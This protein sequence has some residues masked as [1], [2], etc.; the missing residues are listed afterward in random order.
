MEERHIS[1]WVLGIIVVLALVGLFLLFKS[2][3]TGAGFVASKSYPIEGRYGAYSNTNPFPYYAPTYGVSP[4]EIPGYQNRASYQHDW[5]WKM[6]N[7]SNTRDRT[8]ACRI[9]NGRNLEPGNKCLRHGKLRAEHKRAK[10][11]LLQENTNIL[12]NP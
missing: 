9:H 1:L 12:D 11:I 7:T 10:R 2:A 3:K 8:G 4:M 5:A 6:R